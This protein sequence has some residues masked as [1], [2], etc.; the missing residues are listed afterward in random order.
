MPYITLFSDEF[1][2]FRCNFVRDGCYCLTYLLDCEISS[3]DFLV[4]SR[5]GSNTFLY[6]LTML[7]GSLWAFSLED[8]RDLF[9]FLQLKL[10]SKS[11]RA[12]SQIMKSVKLS[13]RFIASYRWLDDITISVHASQ[14]SFFS[15]LTSAYVLSP[16]HL[17]MLAFANWQCLK[18]G[19]PWTALKASP[20]I[21]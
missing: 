11:L 1:L 21:V 6:Y 16:L 13:S 4:D 17:S 19:R 15:S 9:L 20:T 14:F 12:G 7:I 5:R 18:R 2:D 10:S 3:N 8:P